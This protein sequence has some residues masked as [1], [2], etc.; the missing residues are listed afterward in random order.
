MSSAP[1]ISR[2]SPSRATTWSPTAS[3]M[4]SRV[5]KYRYSVRSEMPASAATCGIATSSGLS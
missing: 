4:A 3:N 1:S 2:G 5:G